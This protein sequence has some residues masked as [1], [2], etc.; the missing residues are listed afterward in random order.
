MHKKIKRQ[1]LYLLWITSTPKSRVTTHVLFHSLTEY[2]NNSESLILIL[3]DSFKQS[4]KNVESKSITM[5][6]FIYFVKDNDQV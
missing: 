6:T 5:V 4:E 3:T 1:K 2:F